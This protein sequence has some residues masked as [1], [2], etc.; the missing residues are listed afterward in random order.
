MWQWYRPTEGGRA[1]GVLPPAKLSATGVQ[2]EGQPLG[3]TGIASSELVGQTTMAG[4]RATGDHNI[5]HVCAVPDVSMDAPVICLASPCGLVGHYD[6]DDDASSIME[7]RC[8]AVPGLLRWAL[9][10]L[11]RCVAP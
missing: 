8:A 11:G 3:A 6:D 4:E 9:S 10:A 5:V 7:R 2:Q 1:C